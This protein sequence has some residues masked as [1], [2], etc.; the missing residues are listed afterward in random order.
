MSLENKPR[1][2]IVDDS[3]LM[4]M[5]L[6]QHLHAHG[7]L[8][9]SVETVLEAV[10]LIRHQNFNLVLA[11][12]N[13][14]G[15]SGL[16]FLL[17]LKKNKPLLHVIMM[18]PSMQEEVKAFVLEHEA[19]YFIKSNNYDTLMQI[20]TLKINKR[21]F[22]IQIKDI[23]LFDLAQLCILSGRPRSISLA[24][25]L[26]DQDGMIYFNSGKVVHAEIGEQEGEDA[27]LRIMRMPKGTF[28]EI[29]PWSEPEEETIYMPFDM[30]IMG[31]AT[32]IDEQDR[33][34][35][36][37][38][39]L[40]LGKKENAESLPLM[41]IVDDDNLIRRM[42]VDYFSMQG[43]SVKGLASAREG[44]QW[45]SE[46]PCDLVL[47]DVYMADMTGLEFLE[48]IHDRGLNAKVILMTS[49]VSDHIVKFAAQYGAVKVFRK[50]VIL[51]ELEAF[52]RYLFSQRYFA[53]KIRNINLLDFLQVISFGKACKAYKVHDLALNI[54]GFLYMKEGSV[55]HAEYGEME[56]EEAFFEIVKIQ[57]GFLSELFF[58]P[59]AQQSIDMPLTR[60]I[61][62]TMGRL[63]GS[64]SQ[65]DDSRQFG[66]ET[67]HL[68]VSSAKIEEYIASQQKFNELTIGERLGEFAGIIVGETSR[69]EALQLLQYYKK[70][71]SLTDSDE[72]SL[73]YD[74]FGFTLQLDANGCVEEM[75]F[76]THF[77][78]K[79]SRGIKIGDDIHKAVLIYGKPRFSDQ[80]FS[81][82]NKISFF[83]DSGKITS[84]SLG[85]I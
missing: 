63:D 53:G 6:T 10:D 44:V 38:D 9:I 50:P 83:C 74:D 28:S 15:V 72:Y 64:M 51:G 76:D 35:G 52:I 82:W 77:R 48:W 42:M 31:I 67:F 45:L 73:V 2:L 19:L 68:R 5:I 37:H 49:L 13:L 12:V 22:D 4:R 40:A 27:L 75:V 39:S 81:V 65:L 58:A 3:R 33:D 55:I 8:V 56:G 71:P 26:S 30:L 60:L 66:R 18:A 78:G 23:I 1:I 11:E 17:W 59:P 24:D 20:I 36:T 7:Y 43:F 34:K 84:I 46:N 14:S 41:L 69:E 25:P 85:A 16:D 29:L 62:R 21:G 70:E 79:T 54:K 80:S 47:A 32:V 57:R 61:M